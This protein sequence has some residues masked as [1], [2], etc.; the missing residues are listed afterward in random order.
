MRV[1]ARER[2]AA[3]SPVYMGRSH[4]RDVQFPGAVEY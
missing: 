1:I 2:R 3:A 4:V